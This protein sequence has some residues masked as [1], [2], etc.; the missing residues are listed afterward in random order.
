MKRSA[1]DSIEFPANPFI[2]FVDFFIVLSLILIVTVVHQCL[3]SSSLIERAAIANTQRELNEQVRQMS[4]SA[5]QGVKMTEP[6]LKETAIDGDLQRFRLKGA[7]SFAANSDRLTPHGRVVLIAF[8]K[9]LVLRQGNPFDNKTHPFKR[10]IVSGHASASEGNESRVWELSS[11][12]AQAAIDILRQQCGLHPS[13]LEASGRGA[14]EPALNEGQAA[15]AQ[16]A[17][18]NRRLEIVVVYSGNISLRYLQGRGAP[19]P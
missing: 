11:R 1:P 3:N 10:I 16:V 18:A 5:S 4:A 14:Y 9:Q 19:A 12:R 8:G 17:E 15:P 13:L 6:A 7:L 2:A